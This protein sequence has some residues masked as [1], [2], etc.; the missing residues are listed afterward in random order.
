M[1][2]HIQKLVDGGV[3]RLAFNRPDKKN[4]ITR[5]MYSAL[6]D[7]L[8]EADA[9]PSVRVVVLAAEGDIFTAGNDMLDFMEHPPHAEKDPRQAPVFRFL[10][11]IATAQKPLIASV[12]GAAIG[13]GM[14][15]LLHCD[16]VIAVED[17][18]LQTPFVNLALVPE[19]AS[20]LILP[21][22]VGHQLAS[23]IL[24]TGAKIPAKR[25]YDTGLV[26]AVV[27]A[28]RLEA[29]TME[30]ARSLAALPPVAVRQS[31]QL[32]RG[33][34]AEILQR[35]EEEGAVFSERLQSEEFKEA[36]TAFMERRAPDFS[37]FG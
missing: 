28:D 9:T 35:I 37:K 6:A 16:M 13:V 31:K 12:N 22:L 4:A 18:V 7:G 34:T 30:R 26:N 20:S 24:L 15:M 17:A 5:D 23:E 32:I 36:A 14:T 33:D 8:A 3:M 19:A 21:R 27:A 1:T 29:E 2:E 11:A 10:K 25:A